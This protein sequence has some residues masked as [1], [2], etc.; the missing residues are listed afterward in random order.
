VQI[1]LEPS[2]DGSRLSWVEATLRE[3]TC[4]NGVVMTQNKPVVSVVSLAV[5]LV[6]V[7]L[8]PAANLSST[9]FTG[10]TVGSSVDGQGGWGAS[11]T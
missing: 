7:R 2:E 1:L 9:S 6:V 10:F 4:Q 3:K 11:G 8:S 5:T